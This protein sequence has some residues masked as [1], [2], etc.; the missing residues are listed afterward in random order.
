M[1][2]PN[3]LGGSERDREQI[4]ELHA[5]YLEANAG[6]DRQKLDP[7]WS[8]APEAVFFNLNGHT[9]R[10]RDHWFRL[11][12]FYGRNVRS[13][14]WTPFDIGGVIS[15][16]LAVLWCHRR[17]SREWIGS[18]PPPQDI[19]YAGDEFITRSTMVFRKEAGEWRVVHAH[20]SQASAGER[21]G[22]V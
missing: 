7:I 22:G 1:P 15:T 3:L 5:D 12:E 21:P 6:F 20:F 11:W 14:Y 18:A 9:Y 17:T 10:G 8:K 4:L 16:E 13:S 19:H 2:E